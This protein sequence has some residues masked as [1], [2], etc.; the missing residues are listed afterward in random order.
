VCMSI[1][2]Q[3]R[4]RQLST[5]S[6]PSTA[7]VSLALAEAILL[8]GRDR[9]TTESPDRRPSI[10]QIFPRECGFARGEGRKFGALAKMA[11]F[12]HNVRAYGW[13]RTCARF[14][15]VKCRY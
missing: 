2:K 7:D 11:D 3:L 8:C 10:V 14:D 13:I 5:P 4:E 12:L 9:L 1:N 15:I 6:G